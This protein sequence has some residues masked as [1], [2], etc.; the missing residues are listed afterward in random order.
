[1]QV[2]LQKKTLNLHLIFTEQSIPK[3]MVEVA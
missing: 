3:E 2:Q 1:M